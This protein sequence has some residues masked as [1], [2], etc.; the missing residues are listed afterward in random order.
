LIVIPP[1]F[2]KQHSKFGEIKYEIM[3]QNVPK[4]VYG[5]ISPCSKILSQLI[6]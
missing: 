6:V 2:Q 3:D 1:S 4:Q 5:V